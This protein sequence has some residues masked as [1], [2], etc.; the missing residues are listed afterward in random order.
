MKSDKGRAEKFLMQILMRPDSHNGALMN[1][2]LTEFHRGYPLENLRPL[3]HAEN[4]EVVTIGTWIASELG[5]RGRPLLQDVSPLL[6]H[7]AKKVRFSAIDCILLWATPSND[8]ELASVISLL[9]DPEPGVRWKV[10]DFLFRATTE[11]L[12]SALD[13]FELAIP[14]SPHIR[15]LQWL[16]DPESIE[17]KKVITALQSQDAL[18]RRYAVAA[19]ARISS[20]N[21]DP[22]LCASSN[23]DA[24]VKN[25]ADSAISLLA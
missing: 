6:R 19:A 18:M 20:I 21:R 15:K 23:S 4:Q 5:E 12:Q 3:L 17:P 9:D 1:D 7:P 25:F 22:L 14:K 8:R 2:L 10:M 11:Q 16:L 24:D 13:Y